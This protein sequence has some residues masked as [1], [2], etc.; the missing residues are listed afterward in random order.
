MK[1]SKEEIKSRA[2]T[3]AEEF[4]NSESVFMELVED[5]RISSGFAP[6]IATCFEAVRQ[7]ERS[8]EPSLEQ[9]WGW[10]FSLKE[11]R[12]KNLWKKIVWREFRL[13]VFIRFSKSLNIGEY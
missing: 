12:L 10:V 4:L 7:E 1:P 8:T 13:A 5:Q 11:I 3:H 9:L 6:Y 2:E